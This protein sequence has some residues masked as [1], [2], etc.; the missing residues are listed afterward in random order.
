MS[1][2]YNQH[3]VV[4]LTF[5]ILIYFEKFILII[6]K[7]WT[8]EQE[9]LRD[10]LIGSLLIFS[11]KMW[12]AKALAELYVRR[13]IRLTIGLKGLTEQNLC[14]FLLKYKE[15]LIFIQC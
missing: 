3:T 13:P 15:K 10:H 6:Q 5:L 11:K 2:E 1:G 9:F 4:F 8:I 12:S 14:V 7:S